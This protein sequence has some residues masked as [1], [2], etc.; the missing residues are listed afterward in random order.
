MS[1]IS[2]SVFVNLIEVPTESFNQCTARTVTPHAVEHIQQMVDQG[3][4][5]SRIMGYLLEMKDS[6]S[7]VKVNIPGV[8]PW[9]HDLR[10]EM[11]T[12]KGNVICG[13][14]TNNGSASCYVNNRP[15]LVS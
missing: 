15:F 3:E 13:W 2:S 9:I 4:S 6:L 8:Y 1:I 10:M 5:D 11:I 14:Q 7:G 12:P